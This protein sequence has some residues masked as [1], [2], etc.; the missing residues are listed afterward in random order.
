MNIEQTRE[1]IERIDKINK[2]LDVNISI[3]SK[4]IKKDEKFDITHSDSPSNQYCRSSWCGKKK[5]GLLPSVIE[6]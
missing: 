2:E 6:I 4:L 3:L 5:E 1:F